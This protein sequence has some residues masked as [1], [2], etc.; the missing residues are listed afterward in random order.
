MS[1][2]VGN[3]LTFFMRKRNVSSALSVIKH[4]KPE[5]HQDK[6]PFLLAISVSHTELYQYSAFLL[7]SLTLQP[8][9]FSYSLSLSRFLD[10][11]KRIVSISLFVA[12]KRKGRVILHY[13]RGTPR[14]FIVQVLDCSY[15]VVSQCVRD[16]PFQGLLCS[17]FFWLSFT[18][19]FFSAEYLKKRKG[20]NVSPF[21]KNPQLC[22]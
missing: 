16:T 15:C 6:S 8:F 17:S 22:N 19:Q 20:A 2:F 13:V 4:L 14:S 3:R 10:I 21:A 11:K 7:F 5:C 9:S 12:A 18:L 1:N